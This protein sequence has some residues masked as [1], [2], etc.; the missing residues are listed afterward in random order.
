MKFQALHDV[1]LFYTKTDTYV[2]NQLLT[3]YTAGSVERK[4]QGVLHRF[5]RGYE[6]VLVSDRNVQA[7]GVPENDVWHIPFVAPSAKE[8]LGYPTQ[9]PEALLDRI[10]KASSNEGAIVLDPFCGCGTTVVVAQRNHR[11]WIGIDITY[12]AIDVIK[13]R[14]LKDQL[15]EDKDITVEGE[16]KD[17]YSAKQLFNKSPFQFQ[18][19]CISR[20]PG[21]QCSDSL[22]GDKGVD[23]LVNFQDP[24]EKSKF[25]KGIVSVK[26]GKAV[27]PAMVHELIGTMHSREAAF[28]ILVTQEEPTRG[29]REA[30][31]EA[32]TFEFKYSSDTIQQ[33]IP[34]IQF[35]TVEDLFKKPQPIV[36]PAT[37]VE[38]MRLMPVRKAE[39]KKIDL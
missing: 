19:W 26:G 22:T 12:L 28:G 30:G 7:A 2:F 21:G 27:N 23:G 4:Q 33:K 25:N 24:M 1:I 10:I 20:I 16:P 6:P 5:K 9:K 8:R 13:R 29:M 34:R 15:E 3:P 38:P 18:I 32:G 39:Q 37:I 35:L 11:Q 36:L 14:F 17:A 31:A